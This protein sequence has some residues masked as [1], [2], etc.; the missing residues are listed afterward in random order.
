[1][2]KEELESLKNGRKFPTIRPGD[3]IS[4]DKLPYMTAKEP[5]VIKGMVIGI[6]RRN[7]DTSIRMLNVC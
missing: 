6:T 1:L 4:I 7:S 3:S 2:Q 5:D